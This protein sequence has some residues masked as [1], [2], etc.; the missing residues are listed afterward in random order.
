MAGE[1][2]EHVA[3]LGL[4]GVSEV[5]D[6]ALGVIGEQPGD[7]VALA[8]P[9]GGI[10]R[11]VVG[12]RLVPGDHVPGDVAGDGRQAGAERGEQLLQ[13][14]PHREAVDGVIGTGRAGSWPVASR[15]R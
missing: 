3:D 11:E 2:E 1:R 13:H 15:W 4:A 14:R 10:A 7:H 6:D 9:H 12:H 8:G 5:S